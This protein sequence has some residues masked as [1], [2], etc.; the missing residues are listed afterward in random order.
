VLMIFCGISR[1]SMGIVVLSVCMTIID[2]SG[3]VRLLLET[4][5]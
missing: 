3:Y 1:G 4:F 2:L 5:N